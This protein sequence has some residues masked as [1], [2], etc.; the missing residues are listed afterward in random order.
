LTGPEPSAHWIRGH[1]GRR[2]P[3]Q[4]RTLETTGTGYGEE[5]PDCQ[6]EAQA[7]IHGARLQPLPL[8]RP[9]TQLHSQIRDVQAVF[10]QARIEWRIAGRDQGQLVGMR[11]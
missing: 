7:E 3:V 2:G 8:L 4:R 9:G 5:E 11:A 1:A 6:T 10:P